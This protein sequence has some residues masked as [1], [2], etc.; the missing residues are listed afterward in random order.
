[1]IKLYLE[2]RHVQAVQ[3]VDELYVG[4]GFFSAAQIIVVK[5]PAAVLFVQ[6]L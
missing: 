2:I 3:P 5:G 6:K 1:M 4:A